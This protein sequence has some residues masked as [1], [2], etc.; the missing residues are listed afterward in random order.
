MLVASGQFHGE[1]GSAH[2]VVTVGGTDASSVHLHD[3]LAEVESDACSV[4]MYIA[5]VAAL[6]ETLK[7]PVGVCLVQSDAVV[8]HLN[9]YFVVVLVVGCFVHVDPDH[10]LAAVEGVFE[11]IR[12][13]VADYLV[14]VDSVNPCRH[15][16]IGVQE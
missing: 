13:E 14:E 1:C 2:A 12:E 10:H 6:I 9:D 5:A 11:G 4:E 15:L 3:G 8:G 16:L 7:Q